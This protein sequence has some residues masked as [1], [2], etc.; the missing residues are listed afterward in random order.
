[1]RL[2]DEVIGEWRDEQ[3]ADTAPL[4]AA[5]RDLLSGPRGT[6]EQL[7]VQFT[8]A[9]LGDV[10][11]SWATHHLRLLDIEPGELRGILG[12]ERTGD[13]ATVAGMGEEEF[14]RSLAHHLPGVVRRLTADADPA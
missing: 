3:P 2:V 9:G 5:L 12:A 1:M 4:A 6:L 11:H 10:M 8:E 14:L 13:L 7:G